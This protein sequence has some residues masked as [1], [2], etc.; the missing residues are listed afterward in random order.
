MTLS[1][2]DCGETYYFDN[3]Y[4]NFTGVETTFNQS[5]PVQCNDGY[6]I[7]GDPDIHCLQN[8]SWSTNTTCQIIGMV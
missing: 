4:V 5:V 1:S 6:E 8:G 7:Y 2:L 3:G